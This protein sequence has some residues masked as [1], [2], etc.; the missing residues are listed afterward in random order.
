MPLEIHPQLIQHPSSQISFDQSNLS[1]DRA[2]SGRARLRRSSEVPWASMSVVYDVEAEDK[3]TLLDTYE[4]LKGSE[5][6]YRWAGI[7]YICRYSKGRPVVEPHEGEPSWD[8]TVHLVQSRLLTESD[9]S[10]LN[11]YVY[12]TLV[13]LGTYDLVTTDGSPIS[14][15][16]PA[17]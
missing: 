8:I 3:D 15:L 10:Y 6:A 17:T 9:L 12:G 5:F 11:V 14:G 4:S 7:W 1:V 13:V 2:Y 16:I